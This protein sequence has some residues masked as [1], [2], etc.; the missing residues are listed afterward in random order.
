MSMSTFVFGFHPPDETWRQMKEIW[1]ACKKA[2]VEPPDRVLEFFDFEEPDDAGVQV[3][4][5]ERPMAVRKFQNDHQEGYD[6]DL[7]ELP[8]DVTVVRFVNSW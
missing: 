8:P 5:T 4:L 1:D 2:G 3:N 6:V 7:Q